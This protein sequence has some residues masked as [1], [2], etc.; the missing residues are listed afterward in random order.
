MNRVT[1]DGSNAAPPAGFDFDSVS[2]ICPF[3]YCT[4]EFVAVGRWSDLCPIFIMRGTK[5]VAVLPA[6]AP[7]KTICFEGNML[8]VAF[9]F[10]PDSCATSLRSKLLQKYE[11]VPPQESNDVCLFTNVHNCVV[12]ISISQLSSA[13]NVIL[14]IDNVI[15]TTL[16]T[17]KSY[18]PWSPYFMCA[19]GNYLHCGS[20]GRL[21]VH[22]TNLPYSQK[23]SKAVPLHIQALPFK[24]KEIS[25]WVYKRHELSYNAGVLEK[26]RS[27][28]ETALDHFS[29]MKGDVIRI[30]WPEPYAS[31]LSCMGVVVHPGIVFT[32]EKRCRFCECEYFNRHREFEDLDNCPFK[33]RHNKLFVGCSARGVL[34][35][36]PRTIQVTNAW[37]RA[38]HIWRT[39]VP[40]WRGTCPVD[41]QRS[42]QRRRNKGAYN[43]VTAHFQWSRQCRSS[44]EVRSQRCGVQ[45]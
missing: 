23:P 18:L 12:G 24:I 1:A 17:R 43:I 4:K 2:A 33:D 21:S 10:N 26:M 15:E 40:S 14:N 41:H 37:Q 32:W 16:L 8:Y 20:Y 45:Y 35:N 42:R 29:L 19:H 31:K 7:V 27:T 25:T 38:T 44:L 30:S 9:G 22:R 36:L 3:S 11:Y 28:D 13:E 34:C 39:H 5:V 6:G